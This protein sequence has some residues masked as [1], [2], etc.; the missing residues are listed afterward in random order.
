[1]KKS[2]LKQDH[3]QRINSAVMQ[4]LHQEDWQV[5]KLLQGMSDAFIYK[6]KVD[7]NEYAIKLDNIESR[8]F[9]LGRSY[10]NLH[11]ASEAGIA[12]PVI[13]T[14]A[15]S[16]VVLMKFI[17][18]T[19]LPLSS[20]AIMQQFA[21]TLRKLHDGSPFQSEM[22]L[23]DMLNFLYQKIPASLK[24]QHKLITECRMEAI[25]LNEILSDPLDVKPTHGDLNPSNLLYDGKTIYLVDWLV[26]MP[27]NFY[28]DLACCASFFY[29]YDEALCKTFLTYYFER[30]PTEMEFTKFNLMRIFTN[31]YY[32]IIFLAF[33]VMTGKPAPLLREDQ[34]A[35]LPSYSEF[36]QA[37]GRGQVN[38]GDPATQQ[39]FGFIF[40][41]TAVSQLKNK[42]EDGQ[43]G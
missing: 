40:L 7:N 12:P 42:K 15:E 19:A 22:T 27:Q 30:E 37:I 14:N 11:I 10:H 18:G 26:A 5:D 21:V 35:S 29:F 16:G 13:Y 3:L 34:L 36:M 25:R 8:K 43:N 32:G 17:H 31:I 23:L 2:E 41:K 6:I 9:N 1:M 4:G 20:Q 24:E 39:Q 28:F 33:P 38:L